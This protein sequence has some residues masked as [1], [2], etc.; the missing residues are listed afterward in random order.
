MMDNPLIEARVF[1]DGMLLAITDT[2]IVML[3][4][5]AIISM[6]IISTI[7]YYGL[8]RKVGIDT[9]YA[10]IPIYREVLLF[11]IA[12]GSGWYFLTL[13]I[14]I[15]DIWFAFGVNNRIGKLFGKSLTW[16]IVFMHIFGPIGYYIVGYG[17][18]EEPIQQAQ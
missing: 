5:T 13:F 14:P 16:R 11:K 3:F 9:G 17:K 1:N 18:G 6:L 10:F 2:F 7:M 8:F 4:L 12:Y 15:V